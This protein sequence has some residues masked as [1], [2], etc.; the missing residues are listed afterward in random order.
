MRLEGEIELAHRIIGMQERA[1]RMPDLP[2]VDRMGEFLED[3][4]A[5]QEGCSDRQ[6][7]KEESRQ[8]SGALA[9]RK[10][11]TLAAPPRAAF[12]GISKGHHQTLPSVK[13]EP[14]TPTQ[15]APTREVKVPIPFPPGSSLRD[16]SPQI[17]HQFL[18]RNPPLTPA[19]ARPWAQN[20]KT[21]VVSR[22]DVRQKER[23]EP[24]TW[25]REEGKLLRPS[26]MEGTGRVI[27]STVP[28]PIISMTPTAHISTIPTAYT[29]VATSTWNHETQEPGPRPSRGEIRY[30]FP[31]RDPFPPAPNPSHEPTHLNPSLQSRRDP[32]TEPFEYYGGGSVSARSD[33]SED[34]DS[35]RGSSVG[36]Q[37][38]RRAP[39]EERCNTTQSNEAS[40]L[41]KAL[42]DAISL[43]RL[44]QQEPQ[45]FYGDPIAYPPWRTSFD[46]LV[47][48]QSI[49][50]DEKLMYLRK[51]LGGAAKEPLEGLFLMGGEAAY[52][53]ALEMLKER[54]GHPVTVSGAFLTRFNN[55]PVVR[56][57]DA[58][59]LRKLSDFM[60]QCII[61]TTMVGNLELLDSPTHQR[62]LTLKMPDWLQRGWLE[63]SVEFL[64]KNHS[65][66][67][68]S[69][70]AEFVKK[71]SDIANDPMFSLSNKNSTS[72]GDRTPPPPRSQRPGSSFA[73]V[74]P[75]DMKFPI[76]K[77][78]PERYQQPLPAKERGPPCFLCETHAH[79]LLSCRR[80]LS[81]DPSTRKN[82]L[83]EKNLCFS[84]ALTNQHLSRDCPSRPQ[85]RTCGAPHLTELH[86]APRLNIPPR[87]WS[88]DHNRRP[89]QPTAPPQPPNSNFL[90]PSIPVNAPPPGRHPYPSNADPSSR[91][92]QDARLLI[93]PP[94]GQGPPLAGGY[95]EGKRESPKGNFSGSTCQAGRRLGGMTSM[96]VP[97]MISSTDDPQ[98]EIKTYALLDTMSSI[99]FVT[100]SLAERLK[101][102]SESTALRLNT[103]TAHNLSVPCKKVCGLQIRPMHSRHQHPLS[104]VFSTNNLTLNPD[105]VPTKKTTEGHAHLEKLSQHLSDYDPTCEA[106]VLIGYDHSDLLMPLDVV[107]GQPFAVRTVLGWSIVGP[108]DPPQNAMDVRYTSYVS[109][110][111][112]SPPGHEPVYNVYRTG[113]VEIP[114]VDVLRLMERDF[115]ETETGIKSQEDIRFMEI[116]GTQIHRNSE[117]HYQMPL[118][119]KNDP[120]Q[121]PDNRE[122]ARKRTLGLLRRF[123]KDAAHKARYQAFMD[124]IITSGHAEL[125]P[126]DQIG[127]STRWYIP[128]HGVYSEKKPDKVRV[129]FD[130][131]ASY[132]GAC[133]NDELLQGPDL[134]NSLVGVLC[135]FR[136]G[137]IAFSCDVQKMFHQFH[138]LPEH[139]DY[140]RFL[141]WEDGDTR[142][143][144]RDYRMRVHIFGAVSSPGCANFALQ[145]VGRDN[146]HVNR[147]AAQFLQHDFYVDDGLHASDDVDTAANLLNHAT[148]ICE[149]SK[150]HLHKIVSNSPEL[151]LRFPEADRSPHQV[152]QIAQIDETT[153]VE[154]ILGLQWDTKED[155]FTFTPQIQPKPETR[156]GILSTVASIYDPL[157]LISPLVLQGK[158]ILQQAC[159]EKLDWDVDLT[160][161]LQTKWR[162][163]MSDLTHLSEIQIPRSF[164]PRDFQ[165]LTAIELHHFSDASEIG[166]GQCSYLRVL[167]NR[168][169]V[170]CSLVMSK[171]RVAPLKTVTVPRLELQGAALSVKIAKYLDTE[172]KLN[173]LKHHFWTD[174]KIV[175]AYLANESRRFHV[176]VANRVSQILDFS[177]VG[178]WHHVISED[179]P[180]DHA[181][182]G[183][184]VG[185]LNLSSW[186]RGPK[187]LWNTELPMERQPIEIDET[188]MEIKTC[189]ATH[190][191]SN[192][193]QRFT[194]YSNKRSLVRGIACL[195]RVLRRKTKKTPWTLLESLQKAETQVLR[196]IQAEAFQTLTPVMKKKFE[197]LDAI[198]DTTGCW[199]VGGRLRNSRD[200]KLSHPLILPRDS[201]VTELWV[202]DTHEKLGHAGRTAVIQEMRSQG[203]HVMGTRHVIRRVAQACITCKKLYAGPEGQRMADLPQDRITQAPPFSYCGIDCF[204]PFVVKDGRRHIKRYGLIVTCLA[205]R[206]IHL[207]VL[208]DMSTDAFLSSI[209]NVIAIRGNIRRLR[210]DRGTNFVGAKRELRECWKKMDHDKVTRVLAQQETEWILN[211]PTA[212]HMGGVWERQ[213]RS[214]RSVLSGLTKKSDARLTTSSL[215]TLFYE[216]MAIVNSRPLSVESLEDPLGP[217]PLTP[218]HILTTKSS[219]VLP[220]PGVFEAADL[221]A[222]KAWRRVQFLADEFWN[223]WRKDF[224]ATLQTRRKWRRRQQNLVKGDV[225]ILRDE[226]LCRSDWRLALVEKTYPGDD[227]LVRRCQVSTAEPGQSYGRRGGTVAR[228]TYDRPVHK[229]TLLV[230]AEPAAQ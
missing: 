85:C 176:F 74:D 81:F 95:A 103:M 173:N 126:E 174:S 210:S 132:Q 208:D 206:A 142:K 154:R 180:A 193:A 181:S 202:R 59:G 149:K 137:K 140:L 26:Y 111:A 90:P 201:H 192:F 24:E 61:A 119:F 200:E 198:Q 11:H 99:T 229:L 106:G 143:P 152:Q 116:I 218:N 80:F 1:E 131:S 86:D 64:R 226:G 82:F 153:A 171:S 98:T 30:T 220:P 127:G 178:Q 46:L 110:A 101:T 62:T 44:P 70:L 185:E 10:Q 125:V 122:A 67:P 123:D 53:K 43:N 21:P 205:M 91:P 191:P 207:E 223:R 215:R 222:R 40:Q 107:Q 151:L 118:P 189:R 58:E 203:F 134:I 56:N 45:V 158:L 179:N 8:Q 194:R 163:W 228:S 39:G 155:A 195:L 77:G 84:C 33:S 27:A 20:A 25:R 159:G 69:K 170:H 51:Y 217:L 63:K 165:P 166:Y 214:V 177:S 138:V 184:G 93:P 48:R 147:E 71:R 117:G 102:K 79:T 104:E 13:E 144:L 156:R 141:W 35:V 199:R 230:R 129:V 76:P 187:F 182:R 130:C 73:T 227:G 97:V 164:Y 139:R 100:D 160:D 75:R 55:W 60:Q 52:D 94:N 12:A 115:V 157:G 162:V 16:P 50:P 65:Y 15:K 92:P 209:R 124:D 3:V 150:L 196:H 219:G 204:G 54:F 128:H 224:L 57:N 136:Q 169:H 78:T 72:T 88:A 96:V 47:G 9:P 172:M 197:S 133:L 108:V 66:P 135:R 18:P 186:F 225:V 29:S 5:S 68:F 23:T 146:E 17:A 145:Q 87:N 161:N 190:T 216:V 121:M 83:F 212:S 22:P 113:A 213:I 31:V 36:T 114:A 148:Q 49:S 42:A 28:A 167:D 37:T 4:A 105:N 211:T 221:V 120:P 109:K 38:E 89:P 183:R 19:N 168:D 6:N 112:S 34:L 7:E 188:E 175:L 2:K 41:A 14:D 32:T